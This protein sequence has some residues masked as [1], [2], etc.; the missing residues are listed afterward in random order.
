[1]Q[2]QARGGLP[3]SDYDLISISLTWDLFYLLVIFR[4]IYSMRIFVYA[5]HKQEKST[6]SFDF[7]RKNIAICTM[8]CYNGDEVLMHA[9]FLK[10]YKRKKDNRQ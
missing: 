2:G 9:I 1:M 4:I 5:N 8:I 6:F 3:F 10:K 7:F